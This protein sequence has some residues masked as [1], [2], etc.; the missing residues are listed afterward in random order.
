MEQATQGSEKESALDSFVL[1]MAHWH[2]GE[3][4]EAREWYQRGVKR[5][6]NPTDLSMDLVLKTEQLRTE[7]EEI[8]G[9]RPEANKST[10]IQ[11]APPKSH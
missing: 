6:E 5:M 2:A 11:K 8:A 3:Q 1:A 10:S 9:L 4:T 7:A